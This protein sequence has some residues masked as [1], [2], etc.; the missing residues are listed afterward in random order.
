MHIVDH[1]CNI[2]FIK[3]YLNHFHISKIDTKTI[4]RI[5][6]SHM[7]CWRH[8]HNYSA[9]SRIGNSYVSTYNHCGKKNILTLMNDTMLFH[10]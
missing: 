5:F 10:D 7:E 8:G 6:K 1:I 3:D 9:Y 2:Q 4:F